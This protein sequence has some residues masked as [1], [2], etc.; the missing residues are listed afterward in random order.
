MPCGWEGN[1]RSGVALAVRHR[2]VVYP[3]T[4]SRPRQGDERPAYAVL[5]SI[6][7][8]PS[9]QVI[10]GVLAPFKPHHEYATAFYD[11]IVCC[12]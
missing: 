12:V 10:E 2:P 3:S 5:W 7:H 1:R 8:L 6:S 4:G 9:Y 11:C